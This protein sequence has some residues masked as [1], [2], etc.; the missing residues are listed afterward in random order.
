M[1]TEPNHTHISVEEAPVKAAYRT[2][3]PANYYSWFDAGNLFIVQER[4]R[5]LLKRLRERGYRSLAERRVLEIGCGDG[6]WLREFMK[7]G[8]LPGNTQV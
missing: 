8:V 1:L 5:R 3:K 2:N 7:W 6:L 4:E